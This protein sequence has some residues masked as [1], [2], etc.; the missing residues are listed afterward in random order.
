MAG[1][2]A[3]N[4]LSGTGGEQQKPPYSTLNFEMSKAKTSAKYRS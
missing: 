3:S 1:P 4:R 2:Q